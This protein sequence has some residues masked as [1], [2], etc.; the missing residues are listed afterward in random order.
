MQGDNESITGYYFF[1]GDSDG[2]CFG[3]GLRMSY[4]VRKLVCGEFVDMI[5]FGIDL[6]CWCF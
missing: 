2:N 1:Y 6:L 3:L 5:G 4:V